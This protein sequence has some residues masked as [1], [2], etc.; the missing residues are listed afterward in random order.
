MTP[1]QCADCHFLNVFGY[2]PDR[3][4]P[5]HVKFLEC[6]QRALLDALWAGEPAT[7][8]GNLT[9]IKRITVGQRKFGMTHVLP[10]LGPFPVKDLAGMAH[11]VM[12]LDR[13]LDPGRHAAHVQW[14]TTRK[15]VSAFTNFT[16]ASASGLGD[17][18][19]ACERNRMWFT[20]APTQSLFFSRFKAGLHR[21]VGEIVKPDEPITI[22]LLHE[23]L[24][25]LAKEWSEE[26]TRGNRIRH[27]ILKE[28]SEIACWYCIGFCVA[29]RGEEETLIELAG[30][31]ESMRF[32][33]NP[34]PSMVPH[35]EVVLAGPTKNR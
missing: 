6:A 21:R 20:S 5:Q 22:D 18:V 15:M 25:L 28:V 2:P 24:T 1:F 19:A 9:S 26:M 7:V 35:F 13:S 11:A 4:N 10:P 3:S 23:A 34:P 27:E 33:D 32:L 30:T 16:Q 17:T 31:R 14:S 29:M 12:L 8:G